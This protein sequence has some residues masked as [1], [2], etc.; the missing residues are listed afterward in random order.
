MHFNFK[1][2]LTLIIPCQLTFRNYKILYI[3]FLCIV[4]T[5]KLC[6]PFRIELGRKF[7][8]NSIESNI[9]SSHHLE[10]E[11]QVSKG[12]WFAEPGVELN[13]CTIWC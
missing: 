6:F 10:V 3:C 1:R 7:A 13:R 2:L 8:V 11:H 12:L 5:R 9:L 4:E